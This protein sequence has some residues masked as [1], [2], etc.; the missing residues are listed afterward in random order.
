MDDEIEVEEDASLHQV[1]SRKPSH[2]PLTK[3]HASTSSGSSEAT[4]EDVDIDSATLPIH[5]DEFWEAA[6]PNSP[7]T[8]PLTR[9]PQSPARTKEIHTDSEE[10]QPS[11][12]SIPKEIPATTADET[13]QDDQMVYVINTSSQREESIPS[14]DT[15]TVPTATAEEVARA[16]AI[17]DPNDS[18][19]SPRPV[20]GVRK[21]RHNLQLIPVMPSIG[22]SLKR[23]KFDSAK[24]FDEKN[25]FIGESPYDSAKLRCLRF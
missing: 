7:V 22:K 20:L 24:F 3:E 8:T 13:T 6:H 21:K 4:E 9:E 2:A 11:L 5:H 16:M 12:Q 17:T 19:G 23:P 15:D 10:R 18:T 25:F 1:L 14:A